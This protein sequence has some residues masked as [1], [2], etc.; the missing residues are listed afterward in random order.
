MVSHTGSLEGVMFKRVLL[1][2]DGSAAGR[3]ALKRGAELAKLLNAEVYLLSI[4]PEAAPNAAVWAA[5]AGCPCLVDPAAEH[6][7]SV[8]ESVQY[9]KQ[10]GITAQVL[11]AQ[12]N[13][14]DQIA[15]C[16][17]KLAIDLIVVGHYPKPSGGRWWSGEE[18]GAL[19]ERVSCCVL[20]A[21]SDQ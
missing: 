11:H 6:E 2:F 10:L 20:I 8:R 17:Q 19:A 5:A 7:G 1:C 3:K 4:D 18:R 13:V 16:A 14:I 21:V 12:G 9:L 15:G